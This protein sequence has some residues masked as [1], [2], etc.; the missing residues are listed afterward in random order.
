[1]VIKINVV[2]DNYHH[3]NEKKQINKKQAIECVCVCVCVKGKEIIC[4]SE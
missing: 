3:Y 1:M 4:V 2:Y